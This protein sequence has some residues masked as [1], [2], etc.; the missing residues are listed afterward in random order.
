[1]ATVDRQLKQAMSQSLKLYNAGSAKW[2]DFLS[3]DVIVYSINQ[4]QPYKGLK[5]YKERFRPILTRSKRRTKIMSQDVKVLKDSAVVAQTIQVTEA[6]LIANIRQSVIW[7]KTDRWRMKHLH[8]ALI[9]SLAAT[10]PPSRP[11]AITVLNERIAT[12]AAVLGVAQ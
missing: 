1:M 12:T 4:S 6:G 3:P 5:A 9:G 2:F 10:K 8:S 11:S 7:S